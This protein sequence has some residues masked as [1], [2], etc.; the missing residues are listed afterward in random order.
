LSRNYLF[1]FA[2]APTETVRHRTAKLQAN[3]FPLVT[4]KSDQQHHNRTAR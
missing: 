2:A 4:G 3:S 1:S